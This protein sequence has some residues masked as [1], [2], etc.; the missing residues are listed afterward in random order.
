MPYIN[1]PYRDR[2]P[3]LDR[4]I[5][6]IEPPEDSPPQTNFTVDLAPFPTSF[7]KDGRAVFPDL[8]R[9]DAIRMKG[10]DVRPDTVILATG[11]T[12]D[13]SLF[14]PEGKY[15]TSEEADV[16]EIFRTGDETVAFI[17]FVRPNLGIRV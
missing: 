13:F 3:W 7:D 9:K 8:K 15:P 14:D 11:Y 16:R 2:S 12:Q 1:R 5:K 6:Y 10:R 4:I 17:G